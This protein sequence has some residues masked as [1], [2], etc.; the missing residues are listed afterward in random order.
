MEHSVAIVTG[1]GQGIG[2][3]IAL[4][5]AQ[6]GITVVVVDLREDTAVRVAE[7]IQSAGGLALP[8]AINL[9]LPA[10]RERM[11]Q[12]TL[13]HFQRLD[14]L[15]NNAGTQR[16]D[17]PLD[18]TEEHWD[19]VMNVNAKAVY[20]C[21]QSAL[22]HMVLTQSGC[23]VNIASIAGKMA[24]TVYHP[25]YN[26]SKASVLA[27]T[28]TLALAYASSG[29]R[30]NAVC[31]GVIETPMQ[32]SVDREFA[33]VTGQQ[34]EEIRAE[35]VKRIPLARVG[36]PADVAEVVSFLVGPSAHYMTGQAL[37]V[38]GGMLTY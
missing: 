10:Q 27:M 21:C 34:P 15:V 17:M 38:D 1:A 31:P 20:F 32:E 6:D 11:M 36:E 24:S 13:E 23:I 8:L 14:I 4:R 18:V 29:I 12:T 7:E 28:K 25:I 30:V 16:V 19:T 2:R 5:L 35:R 37:N 3:A 26:V 33:R 9:T 22:K